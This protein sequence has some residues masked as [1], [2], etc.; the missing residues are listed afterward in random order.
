MQH[1]HLVKLVVREGLALVGA[2]L[3]LGVVSSVLLRSVVQNQVYGVAPLNPFV[4][5]CVAIL[6][7]VV[8]LIACIVPAR[9]AMQVDPV[10]VLTEQ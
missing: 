3:M 7:A 10:V 4:M 2:G 6:F 8:A 9:R 5:G 1:A